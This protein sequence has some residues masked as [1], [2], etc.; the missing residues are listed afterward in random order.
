MFDQM[1]KMW[2]VAKREYLEWV[3]SPWFLFA[4]IFG[5]VVFAALFLL[6]ALTSEKAASST[7]TNFAT[8]LYNI[9]V[10][11]A[12]TTGVGERIAQIIGGGKYAN[13][14]MPLV[15]VVSEE[16]LEKTE[17]AAIHDIQQEHISGYIVV[18]SQTLVDGTS[19]YAGRRPDAYVDML[20]IKDAIREG[21]IGLRLE[22]SG[23]SSTKIDS[24]TIIDPTLETSRI[25]VSAPGVIN[26]A[27]VTIALF[28]TIL[29]YMSI[30]LYGQSMLS[31][32]VE[33]KTTRMSEIIISSIR[34]STLLAGKI[35]GI[36][37]VGLTQQ[38]VWVAVA[39]TLIGVSGSIP[40]LAPVLAAQGVGAGL[41]FAIPV[42]TAIAFVVFFLLGV[43]FFGSLYAAVGATVSSESDARHA[44]QPVVM[45]LIASVF[46]FQ[47][48]INDPTSTLSR[49]LTIFPLSAP[50]LMPL[51]MAVSDVP[52]IEV[53]ASIA[54]LALACIA[55]VMLAA[56]IYRVGILMYGKRPNLAEL[57]RWLKYS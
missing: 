8:A 22:Q 7:S 51:R 18:D 49:V 19:R 35:L 1:P 27:R 38:L 37:A 12:T 2:V 3:R 56:R 21:L 9:N 43:V 40:A 6:P 10:L 55:V 39:A 11:D 33:E 57:F 54:L 41:S 36:S 13:Q 24:I 5:P 25:D 29:L 46:F 32:V 34:P 42:G 44:A 17:K 52:A 28:I 26:E 48:I 20:L 50:I 15:R 45:L 31:S 16:D 23:M 14:P 30:V 47:P 53:A 4:T